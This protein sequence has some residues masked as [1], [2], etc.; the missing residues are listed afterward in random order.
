[1]LTLYCFAV[2]T[3]RMHAGAVVGKYIDTYMYNYVAHTL[4][5]L[6]VKRHNQHLMHQQHHCN[7]PM[8]DVIDKATTQCSSIDE[9]VRVTYIGCSIIVSSATP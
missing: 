1:M 9:N 2:S 5:L 6:P 8:V 7:M 3:L 4:L